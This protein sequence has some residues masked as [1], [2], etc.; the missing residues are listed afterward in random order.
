MMNKERESL[1]REMKHL[2]AKFKE[3]MR[4]RVVA[5]PKAMRI[6]GKIDAVRERLLMMDRIDADK[7]TIRNVPIENILEIV[8][9]PLLADVMNDLVAGVDGMLRK[10]NCSDTVFA[11][12]VRT[13][14]K[15][16]LDMVD[17]LYRSECNLPKLLDVDDTLV[18]AIRK[19]LMSYI[20]Q[21]VNINDK[22]AQ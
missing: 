2:C 17:T 21:R 8:A 5:T 22:F 11:D 18:D 13:I 9:I 7:L 14:R 6:S 3:E 1:N 16:S 10:N 15:A 20:T 19:K 4:G 12:Y